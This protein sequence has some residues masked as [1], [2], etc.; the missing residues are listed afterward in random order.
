MRRTWR[1]NRL[2]FFI[3]CLLLCAGMVVASLSGF[4]SPLEDL[5]TLPLHALTGGLN[6]TSNNLNATLNASSDV[7]VLRQRVAALEEELIKLQGEVIQLREVASDYNRLTGLL[8]Y[9][10]S[11][12]G[13]EFVTADV[14]GVDAQSLVRSIII[15]R[16]TRDG[17]A[18]GMPVQTDLGLV[19]RIFEVSASSARVQLITDQNSA[20]SG[21]LQTSRA[22]GSVRGRGLLAGNLRMQF[23]PVDAEVT[24]GDLVVTSG[25]G[26][27][28]PPD[29]VI[30][31]VTSRRDFE[32][33][34]WQEAEVSSLIDFATLE[35]VLVVTNF[36]PADIS[37]F[38]TGADGGAP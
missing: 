14:I 37:V 17:L 8:D 20:V 12:T 16:G 34:L 4:L 21:R 23:I 7:N 30:G 38:D 13:R 35:F 28:F 10:S 36:Q 18:L 6:R 24:V 1:S 9:T 5:V 31:Q 27:N 32:F 25:L 15:N 22:E 33:E 11:L 19:G 26:G 2:I 29:I 3:L